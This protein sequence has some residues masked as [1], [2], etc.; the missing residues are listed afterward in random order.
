MHNITE[1][2]VLLD[3]K[4]RC[5]V[6]DH[7]I[8]AASAVDASGAHPSPG[9]VSICAE[10]TSYL[11]YNDDLSSHV[12]TVDEFVTLPSDI[13]YE[14]TAARKL[15]QEFNFFRKGMMDNE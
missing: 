5:P 2:T 15:K 11:M 9:D 6:C 13:I 14:L 7:I 8:D 1:Y 10:C 3:V 12:I 4:H